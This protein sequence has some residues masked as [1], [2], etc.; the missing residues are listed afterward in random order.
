MG[1]ISYICHE[2]DVIAIDGEFDAGLVQ[3]T[4]ELFDRIT[5]HSIRD[6]AID[7]SGTRFIDSSGIGCCVFL[8]KRLREQERGL[9]LIG[10]HGQPQKLVDMLRVDKVIP[11]YPDMNAYLRS[12][13]G[14]IEFNLNAVNVP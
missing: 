14:E 5:T 6:V 8:F 13:G 10:L 3:A 12:R 1:V 9:A 7:L 11:S 2:S 4:R